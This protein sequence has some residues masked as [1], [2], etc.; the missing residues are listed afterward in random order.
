MNI[1]KIK[2][3]KGHKMFRFVGCM[4]DRFRSRMKNDTNLPQLNCTE[5]WQCTAGQGTETLL[6]RPGHSVQMAY[7]DFVDFVLIITPS[8][9][10][11]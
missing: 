10:L 2:G 6:S 9:G 8:V 11:H 1:V 5:E 3:F 4:N 7:T